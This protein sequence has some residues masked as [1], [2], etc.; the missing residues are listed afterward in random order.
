MVWNFLIVGYLWLHNIQSLANVTIVIGKVGELVLPRTSCLLH[1]GI[2][3]GYC[4][5]VCIYLPKQ[6]SI[7]KLYKS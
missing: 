6:A 4:V 2:S 5:P 7:F 1:A 3:H